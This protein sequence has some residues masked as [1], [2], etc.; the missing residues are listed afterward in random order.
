M[1]AQTL[2]SQPIKGVLLMKKVKDEGYYIIHG[3]M[4]NRL[5]LS[6]SELSI[7]AIIYGFSQDNNSVFSGSIA[8][9]SEWLNTSRSTV[10]RAL[11]SLTEKGYIIK[12]EEMYNGVKMN[13]YKYSDA[14]LIQ[15]L[16]SSEDN[17]DTMDGQTGSIKMTPDMSDD[18]N[19]EPEAAS[20]CE[21]PTYAKQDTVKITAFGK[22]NRRYTFYKDK[23]ETVP[24]PYTDMDR[25]CQ[26]DTG[27]I[28]ATQG[29]QN[30]DG[31]SVNMTP[32]NIAYNIDLCK[33]ESISK[34]DN[35]TGTPPIS[36]SG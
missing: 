2:I 20:S 4:L 33:K 30:Q 14:F 28:K 25:G 15:R 23:S 5:G 13:T 6:G 8:Y 17:D 7:Y 31:V 21:N 24:F 27:G 12:N 11:K 1:S 18:N 36:L 19:S 32:N 22:G 10:I 16:L 26:N 9:L 3:W 34:K 35:I 29:M